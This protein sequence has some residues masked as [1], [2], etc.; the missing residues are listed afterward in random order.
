V[1]F[2]EYYAFD[3]CVEIVSKARKQEADTATIE[4]ISMERFRPFVESKRV[5]FRNLECVLKN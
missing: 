2:E 5:L 1:I 4:K 3:S